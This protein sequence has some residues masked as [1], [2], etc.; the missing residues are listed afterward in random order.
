MSESSYD[1][2]I[3]YYKNEVFE[4]EDPL[5][6]RIIRPDDYKKLLGQYW[7][8]NIYRLIWEIM[9][10]TGMR[11]IEACSLHADN[12]DLSHDLIKYKVSKPRNKKTPQNQNIKV[13]KSR[14]T[15][16]SKMLSKK[17]SDYIQ[18]MGCRLRMGFL[19]PSYE[20]NSKLPHINPRS[21]NKE[22]DRIRETLGGVFI[23]RNS[24][25]HHLI[26]PHSFRR[27]WI[28]RHIRWTGNIAETSR[29]IGHSDVK[30]TYGY[31][32]ELMKEKTPVWVNNEYV[33]IKIPKISDDQ[34]RITSFYE[35]D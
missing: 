10:D 20:I 11:P 6:E 18:M 3:R 2:S 14:I 9:W 13:Y 16:I 1:R 22:L 17:I 27:S 25:G 5:V 12:L 24:K 29:A 35:N 19:F 23:K 15:C 7:D 8:L 32:Y 30:T 34:T 21:L 28:S 4:I 26:G 31:Y 33:N